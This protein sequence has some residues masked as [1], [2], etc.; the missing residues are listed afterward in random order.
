MKNIFV[1]GDVCGVEEA[2]IDGDYYGDEYSDTDTD[3]EPPAPNDGK[4]VL[5]GGDVVQSA[6]VPALLNRK[7]IYTASLGISLETPKDV[8]YE[9]VAN[10]TTIEHILN[11]KQ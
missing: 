7:I 10:L 3:P 6:D 2:S 8:Y 9:V 1:A 4:I 5:E 11:Q